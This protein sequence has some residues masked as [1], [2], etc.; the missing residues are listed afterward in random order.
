MKTGWKSIVRKAGVIVL[1]YVVISLIAVFTALI[2]QSVRGMNSDVKV[3]WWEVMQLFI[4]PGLFLVA[5]YIG[6]AKCGLKKLKWYWVLLAAVVFSALLLVLW[7]V[8]LE[9]YVLCNLPAAEGGYAIDLLLRKTIITY[10]YEYTY[11]AKTDKYRYV[12]LP[13]IHFVV[14]I[15][16]WLCY[17]WGNR[18]CISRGNQK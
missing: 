13:L 3:T 15:L 14:R 17:L 5:G 12:V 7:Y 18:I 8:W 1:S 9:G 4:V 2:R 6:T 10:G 11:L 16:Y